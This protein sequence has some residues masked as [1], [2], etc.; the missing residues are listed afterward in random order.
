MADTDETEQ[1]P[2]VQAQQPAEQQPAAEAEQPAVEEQPA[3][4]PEV[5]APAEPQETLTPKER[6]RRSRSAHSGPAGKP[7]SPQERHA[8]RLQERREKARARSARRRQEREKAAKAPK[9]QV[10][11]LAPVH[12]PKRGA[13][14]ERQGVVVSSKADKTIT[15]RIDVAR[16]HRRYEKIVRSSATLHAHDESNEAHE[17]DTVRVVESRPLS[18]MKRWRLLE[19]LERAR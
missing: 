13:P 14:K 8:E 7:R 4:A 2:E 19:V 1:I 18:R 11:D 10:S 6:R 17:G 9:R 16:Q 5:A 15:V 12:E 3:A